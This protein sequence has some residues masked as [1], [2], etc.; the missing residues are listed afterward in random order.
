MWHFIVSENAIPTGRDL[1]LA[2]VDGDGLVALEFPCRWVDGCWIAARTG[3]L[4]DV[5]PTH[6]REWTPGEREHA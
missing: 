2:V 6:W 3:L 5:R 1:M 4:I